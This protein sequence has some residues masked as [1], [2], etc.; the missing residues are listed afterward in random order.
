MNLPIYQCLPELCQALSNHGNAV[1]SAAPGAGKSTIVPIELIKQTFLDGKKILML[2]PR[3]V[4]AMAIAQRMSYLTKTRPGELI[5]HQVRFSR[6]TSD[7]TRIEVMTEGILTRRIQKDPFLEN[8]G[9]IILDEFHERSIHSDLCLALCREIQKDVRPDLKILVMSATIDCS[10]LSTFLNHCPII[11]AEGFLHPVE[12]TYL[13]VSPGRNQ[14]AAMADLFKQIFVKSSP[15]ES[16]LVFLPGSGEISLFERELCENIKSHEILPLHGSLNLELQQKILQ[17]GKL[18]RIVLSTNIAETSL[19]IEGITTVIDSGYCRKNQLNPENGLESLELQ[20]IS[21]ASAGQRTG[22]A[23][24]LRPGRAFRLWSQPEHDALPEF[25]IPEIH[26]IDLSGTVLELAGWGV[27]DPDEFAWFEAPK[28]AAISYA[29]ELLTQLQAIDEQGRITETGRQMMQL[30]VHP[31]LARMLSLAN[32][33]GIPELASM[34]AAIIS[35]RDFIK[36]R[37]S[38]TASNFDTDLFSR[39]ELIFDRRS[40][41]QPHL[42]DH[43]QLHRVKNTGRQIYLL[44]GSNRSERTGPESWKQLKK[45]LLAAFPDRLCQRRNESSAYKIC[46]G[47]GL[48]L[49]GHN[50]GRY[51]IALNLD[52]RLRKIS[53]DGQIFLHCEINEE[54]IFEVLKPLCS[55]NRE[56]FFSSAK[57]AVLARKITRYEQLIL[58]ESEDRLRPEEQEMASKILVGQAFAD[59]K[60]AFDL[61][62]DQVKQF[63]NRIELVARHCPEMGFDQLNQEWFKNNIEDLCIGLTSFADLKKASLIDAYF[64]S[65]P[66]H[67]KQMFE[68]LVP[69]KI[70]VPSGSCLK[71]EYPDSGEPFLKVK[72]Q[73]VFGLQNSPTLCRGRV[74][75]II[76]LLSPAQRP[77]QI[78]SDL[79]SFWENG[80]KTVIAELKGRYPKHPWPDDPARGVAFA[81][82]KKQLAKKLKSG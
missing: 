66:Y 32:T 44:L 57:K 7:S 35:E 26:R 79:K 14:F 40:T 37:D 80:Y 51:I 64:S 49:T 22:R 63:I 27:C 78:T 56:I 52:A 73:E 50:P 12:I 71:I 46:T 62:N 30:P 29:Q 55:S 33:Y 45:A 48:S 43:Q 6:N 76:H 72:I 59:F 19:T 11:E 4:A 42:I 17:P 82:T 18:P 75:L 1:L 68:E 61:E 8:T 5:G 2:Q 3:R 28:T 39:I 23:G 21:K 77:V 41:I 53:N 31:R 38:N 70:S 60:S 13:P 20:R 58:A 69:E 24:R 34:A 36:N 54:S 67:F 81:G 74:K 25:D 9:L 10:K 15:E 16:Y 47:Q 65:R